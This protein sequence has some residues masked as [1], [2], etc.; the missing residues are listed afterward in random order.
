MFSSHCTLLTGF[1]PVGDDQDGFLHHP[2]VLCTLLTGF[3]PVGDDQ[4]G[5]L[6]HPDTLCTLLTGFEPV[7]GDQGEFLTAFKSD[8][9]VGYLPSRS[10]YHGMPCTCFANLFYPRTKPYHRDAAEC[11]PLPWLW[12]IVPPPSTEHTAGAQREIA[13]WPSAMRDHSRGRTRFAFPPDGGRGAYRSTYPQPPTPG[14]RDA[15]M[16]ALVAWA[17]SSF[18][19]PICMVYCTQ[20]FPEVLYEQRRNPAAF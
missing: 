6:Y 14:S 15:H 7:G 13:C 17:F 2:D 3:E 8:R 9:L 4:G 19:S 10:S 12:C 20:H 18:L 11:G 1:E 5:F 16:D